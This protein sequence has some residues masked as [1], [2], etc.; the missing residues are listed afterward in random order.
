MSHITSIRR[1]ATTIGATGLIA[2]ALAGPASARPDPGTG[3]AAEQHCSVSCY[4]GPDN[5][6]P[7]AATPAADD[8]GIE[9]FQLGA[10]LLAGLALAGAGIAVASRRSQGHVAHPA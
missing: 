5:A 4:P 10:G 1:A 7:A 8:N 9:V 3:S 6:A 2:I